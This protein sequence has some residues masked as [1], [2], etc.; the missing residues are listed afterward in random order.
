MS[1]LIVSCLLLLVLSVVAWLLPE[2]PEQSRRA[3]RELMEA[4]TV[5]LQD[6]A[7]ILHTINGELSPTST[8]RTE[9]R[10]SGAHR[11]PAP[12]EL[13]RGVAALAYTGCHR[14]G[15][16]D[17]IW[18]VALTGLRFGTGTARHALNA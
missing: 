13:R 5:R 3:K 11:A 4:D 10:P 1:A 7:D 14:A 9:V 12:R 16:Q 2:H 6:W 17:A 18:A 8:L 15:R